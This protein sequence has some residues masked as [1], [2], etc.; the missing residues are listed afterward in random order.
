MLTNSEIKALKALSR[1]RERTR[2][3]LFVAEGA[4]LVSELLGSFSCTMLVVSES[5]LQEIQQCL[6][7]LSPQS[8]P[9]LLEVVPDSF[10][11]ARI[12]SLV[13]PQGVLATFELPRMHEKLTQSSDLSILLDEVQDPGNMGTIIRTAD[14]FGVKDIYLSSGCVDPFSPKVVQATMGA[15]A[16]V[17]LH[18]LPCV[19]KFL[20]GYQGEICGTFLG[21]ELL[22]RAE[23]RPS[24]EHPTLIVMGNEGKG[25]SPIVEGFVH[26]RITI[27]AF[28]I[29]AAHTESLNVGVATAIVLSEIRRTQFL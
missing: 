4:K 2:Q 13:Q 9:N 18:R 27:P 20:R 17:H 26:R 12:S 14:W 28:P 16:R 3:G 8:R 23:L 19:E 10:D 15:L 24:L 29:G 5:R 7:H 22:Y 1:S 11:F 21:G 6:S 25:I